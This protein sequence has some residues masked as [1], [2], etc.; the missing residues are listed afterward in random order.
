ML[1]VSAAK[2]AS[3][4]RALGG[5]S[6]SPRRHLQVLRSPPSRSGS[7]RRAVAWRGSALIDVQRGVDVVDHR[8]DGRH[9][10]CVVDEGPPGAGV[11]GA[12]H[13]GDGGIGRQVDGGDGRCVSSAVVLAPTWNCML[14]RRSVPSTMAV[15][16]KVVCDPGCA[17]LP[18]ISS[19][20]TPCPANGACRWCRVGGVLCR[21]HRQL[22]HALQGVG[23][24]AHRAFGWSGPSRCRRS[25]C[26][27]RR[28]CRVPGRSCVRRSPDRRHRPWPSSRASPDESRCIDVAREPCDVFRLRCA[29]SDAMFVLIVWGMWEHSWWYQEPAGIG[30]QAGSGPLWKSSACFPNPRNSSSRVAP[31][32]RRKDGH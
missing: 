20:G 22:T 8:V 18:W 16:L 3:M 30:A 13:R 7:S 24:L 12:C 4:M 2:S 1:A 26:G 23:H 6:G 5:R 9:I 17:A 28:S 31:A 19:P 11:V 32:V 14:H 21:L 27:W 15:P 25:R 10:G 29:F